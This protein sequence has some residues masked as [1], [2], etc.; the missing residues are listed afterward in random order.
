V[1][2]ASED[3]SKRLFCCNVSYV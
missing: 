3:D 2:A 1:I